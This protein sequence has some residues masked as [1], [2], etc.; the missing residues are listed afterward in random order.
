MPM[1]SAPKARLRLVQ[2]KAKS[3]AAESTATLGLEDAKL[4]ALTR[5]RD[6]EAF[7]ALYRRHAEFAMNLA[8]RIQGT[9]ADV[10]DVVHDA[11]IRA[12]QRMSELRDDAA[13]RP[14]LG[15][16]VV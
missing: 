1:S 8:V 15:S 16:I 11:F 5:Q 2:G 7:E 9:A 14:W 4:V 10:E 13:F 3:R 12:H 6:L